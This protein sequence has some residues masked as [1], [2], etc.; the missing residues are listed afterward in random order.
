M[1]VK[2]LFQ[3][4]ASWFYEFLK[5]QHKYY[6][7]KNKIREGFLVIG[8][9]S[10][11]MPDV[12]VYKGSEAK[13]VIRKYCSIAP[14][15]TFITGGIHPVDWVSTYPF[16][17]NWRLPGAEEDGMPATK[18]DIIVDN[19]VW[20]GTHTIVLSG[21]T[22]GDGTVICSGAVVTKDVP[23]YSIAGGVPAAVIKRRF[24]QREIEALEKIR[25]WEWDHEKI[26]KNVHLLSE[27]QVKVFLRENGKGEEKG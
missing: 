12:H 4:W 3:F 18:G 2:N 25:W 8:E 27:P 24:S 22:I 17:A 23:P 19:D 21:V 5:K 14:D 13:V 11:G 7:Y 26:L 6:H 20:I 16:R 10:Y 15:V 9:H 1:L